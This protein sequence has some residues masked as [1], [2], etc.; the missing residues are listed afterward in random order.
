MEH[1]DK[2]IQ[3]FRRQLAVLFVLKYALPLAT[4]YAFV[5]GAVVLVLRAGTDVESKSLLWGLAGV[6]VCLAVAVVLARRRMPTETAMRA[7]LDG[8]NGCGGLLMAE[9]EQEL[10]G[11]RQ[12]M[13]TLTS[14]TVRWDGRRGGT[15]LALAVGFVLVCFLVP[16]GLADLLADAPLDVGQEITRLMTQIALLKAE[17]VLD[18]KRAEALAEKLA[19]LHEHASG[20]EPARTLEALDH[21]RHLTQ[22]AARQ[23][24]EQSTQSHQR[25][26]EAQ[27]LAQALEQNSDLIDPK[28]A[29]EMLAELAGLMNDNGLDPELTQALRQQKLNAQ[30]LNKVAQ[31]ILGNKSGL[32]R[33]MGKLHKAGLIDD[34]LLTRC[35]KAGECDCEGLREFLC[36]NKCYS[37]D[38]FKSKSKFGGKGGINRGS[39]AAPMTWGKPGSEDDFKFKEDVLPPSALDTLKSTPLQEM[40][41]GNVVHKKSSDPAASG[42]LEGAAA[43]SGSANTQ[44]ILPRHR[45]AVERYFE[46]QMPTKK[47]EN[48]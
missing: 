8:Q 1:P 9:A 28:L 22:E 16:K 24:A 29:K 32:M 43:G 48:K 27:A 7:L 30:Q 23:A 45:A 21:L 38:D 34:E 5:W 40:R 35:L 4:V 26:G 42:A 18:P 37:L 41:G 12:R 31:A 19:E 39:G 36:K 15:L 10:G 13:P 47:Q 3:N 14:P 46:R 44:V 2:A 6:V 11:W 20:K 25:L 17:A 33:R